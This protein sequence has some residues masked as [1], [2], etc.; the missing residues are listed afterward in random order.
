LNEEATAKNVFLRE[1]AERF[2]PSAFFHQTSSPG[3]SRHVKK[4]FN[5]GIFAK[6]FDFS[7]FFT[8]VLEIGKGFYCHWV[9]LLVIERILLEEL[10][11]D[12]LFI[13]DCSVK[14]SVQTKNKKGQTIH[15]WRACNLT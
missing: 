12:N 9:I 13:T 7:R 8:S 10:S 6:V 15:L 11:T 1:S 5:V 3:R 2:S 4:L 14:G